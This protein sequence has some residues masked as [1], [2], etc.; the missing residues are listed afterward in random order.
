M[1]QEVEKAATENH[2]SMTAEIIARLEGSFLQPMIVEKLMNKLDEQRIKLQEA[3]TT[4]AYLEDLR[5]V[6]EQRLEK[7]EEGDFPYITV[8][9]D[10]TIYV[11]LDANGLPLSWQEITLHLG[12]ISRQG[13]LKIDKLE[14]RIFNADLK[15]NN[16]REEEFFQLY[17]K[18]R[19]MRLEAKGG[20]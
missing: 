14:A 8:P 13:N 5:K 19:A 7:A 15:T 18:Y 10:Q 20:Q 3:I 1:K 2:R 12:E 4:N 16:E 9:E 11:I 6:L 17:E